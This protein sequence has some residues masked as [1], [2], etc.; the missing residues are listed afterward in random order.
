MP[1]CVIIEYRNTRREDWVELV[2][3]LY[4]T[5]EEADEFFATLEREES[6]LFRRR[7]LPQFGHD[8]RVFQ[9]E[10]VGG[11]KEEGPLIRSRDM[12]L[13]VHMLNEQVLSALGV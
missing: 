9:W 3:G 13:R 2:P 1:E 4:L 8:T 12:D 11:W 7:L 5:A 6:G 10:P